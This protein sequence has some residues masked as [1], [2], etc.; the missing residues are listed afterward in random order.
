MVLQ[1]DRL[2]PAILRRFPAIGVRAEHTLV[3]T[4]RPTHVGLFCIRTY[5]DQ[6]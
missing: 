5:D 6:N 3:N 2:R 4:R 1:P